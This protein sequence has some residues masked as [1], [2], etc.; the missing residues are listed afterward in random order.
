MRKSFA[1][2]VWAVVDYNLDAICNTA[3]QLHRTTDLVVYSNSAFGL[4]STSY[5]NFAFG[6]IALHFPG[7]PVFNILS[8]DIFPASVL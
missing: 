5:L 8:T 4:G 3:R 7:V 1:V 6:N 2:I